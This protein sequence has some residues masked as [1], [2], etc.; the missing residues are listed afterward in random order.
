MTAKTT[1]RNLATIKTG[2]WTGLVSTV[3][4]VL[5]SSSLAT[6]PDAEKIEMNKLVKNSVDNPISRKSLLS[7]LIVY[8]AMDGL[9]KSSSK[10]AA[11]II[12]YMG[13]L[14]VSMKVFLAIVN[15]LFMCHYQQAKLPLT[16][17]APQFEFHKPQIFHNSLYTKIPL[18]AI[19]RNS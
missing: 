18:V 12:P 16:R 4:I 17:V 7:S 1:P 11:T 8:I 13:C 15:N 19:V 3:I 14:R 6:A 9:M 10:A 5:F 2:R